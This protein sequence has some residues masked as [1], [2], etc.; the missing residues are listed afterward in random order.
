LDYEPKRDS[1]TYLYGYGGFNANIV[2]DFE[3]SR[4]VFMEHFD[5]IYA[6]PNI[7]GGGSVFVLEIITI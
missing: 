5:G 7:R 6:V 4:I 2:P 3:P 1:P